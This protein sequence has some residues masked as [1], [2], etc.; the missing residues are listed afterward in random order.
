MN[1]YI[2]G[3]LIAIFISLYI[4]YEHKRI[5]RLRREERREEL[6]SRRQEFLEKL[7]ASKNKNYKNGVIRSEEDTP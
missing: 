6:N 7:V 1:I 4:F 3:E 2:P 5:N